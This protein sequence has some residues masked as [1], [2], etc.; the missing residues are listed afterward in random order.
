MQMARGRWVEAA[1]GASVKVRRLMCH[2]YYT[3]KATICQGGMCAIIAWGTGR[4]EVAGDPTGSDL[5]FA[6]VARAVWSDGDA[7]RTRFGMTGGCT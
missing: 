6:P 1:V 3:K 7:A 5:R 2:T 4:G